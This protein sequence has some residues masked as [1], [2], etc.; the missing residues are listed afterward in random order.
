MI[1]KYDDF[2]V[3]HCYNLKI[4]FL[5]QLNHVNILLD[6]ILNQKGSQYLISIFSLSRSNLMTRKREFVSD[7]LGVTTKCKTS[8]RIGL[9]L[10]H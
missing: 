8:S 6:V 3:R 1:Q 10:R 2:L 5:I 9:D 7:T 4:N